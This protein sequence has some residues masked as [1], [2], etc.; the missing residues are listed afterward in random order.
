MLISR[1]VALD[2]P[3]HLLDATCAGRERRAV[4]HGVWGKGF[5]FLHA[6][7]PSLGI[8]MAMACTPKIFDRAGGVGICHSMLDTLRLVT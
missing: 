6:W 1:S 7:A 2:R 8:G 3:G 5:G 4:L